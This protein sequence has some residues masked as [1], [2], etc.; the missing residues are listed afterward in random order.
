M[1]ARI[2]RDL[3]DSQRAAGPSVTLHRAER[4]AHR[5]RAGNHGRHSRRLP[6][7]TLTATSRIEG[8]AILQHHDLVTAE[9]IVDANVLEQRHRAPR[10]SARRPHRYGMCGRLRK[11]QAFSEAPPGSVCSCGSPRQ[12]SGPA[13]PRLFPWKKG[14]PPGWPARASCTVGCGCHPEGRSAAEESRS[15]L[16]V[17]GDRAR[18]RRLRAQRGPK[19]VLPRFGKL[20]SFRWSGACGQV[21]SCVRPHCVRHILRRGPVWRYA[22]RVQIV[23]VCSKALAV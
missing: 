5:R 2:D 8:T 16:T 13:A 14:Q 20:H 4:K 9:A 22:G 17:A 19:P 11:M 10:R 7:M 1:R 3:V 12:V 15:G 21:L 18:G 23:Q 6:G